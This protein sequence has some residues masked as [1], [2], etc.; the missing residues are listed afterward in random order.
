MAVDVPLPHCSHHRATRAG[1]LV[2]DSSKQVVLVELTVPRENPFWGK[3][4]K[5]PFSDCQRAGWRV[6]P[7]AYTVPPMRQREPLDGCG[8]KE[9]VHGVRRARHLNTSQGL[10]YLG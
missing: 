5:G 8:S 9:E 7:R 6:S 1:V 3:P 10:I 4:V 2:S